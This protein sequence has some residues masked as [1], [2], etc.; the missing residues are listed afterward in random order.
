TAYEIGVRL[1][2]SEMC[3]RDRYREAPETFNKNYIAYLSAGS[4][5]PPEEKLKKYFGIEI[6]RQLFEDA[7]DVVELRIQELNKLENG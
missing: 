3:I 4:T 7:M 6:N 2:G 5:M 1:V